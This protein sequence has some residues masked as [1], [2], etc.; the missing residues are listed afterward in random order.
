MSTFR[1]L[2]IPADA[3]QPIREEKV[4]S[5]PDQTGSRLHFLQE[6]VGGYVER[7]RTRQLMTAIAPLV[8][9]RVTEYRHPALLVDEEGLLKNKAYNERASVFYG[10][11]FD[12]LVGDAVLLWETEE[13]WLSLPD[14]ITPENLGEVIA[15]IR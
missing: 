12:A 7:V 2:V 4:E 9:G 1:V 14:S 3:S 11:A 13:D 15:K 6:L 8:E 10:D 5:G